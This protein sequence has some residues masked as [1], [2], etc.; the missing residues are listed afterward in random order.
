MD[1]ILRIN[2]TT[3]SNPLGCVERNYLPPVLDKLSRFEVVGLWFKKWICCWSSEQLADW[4]FNVVTRRVCRAM[5]HDDCEFTDLTTM[6]R[7]VDSL[8]DGDDVVA[9]NEVEE[10]T[11]LLRRSVVVENCIITLPDATRQVGPCPVELVEEECGISFPTS[12][13][14]NRIRLA[15]KI[16][17]SKRRRRRVVA[18]CVV[19]LVNLLRAKYFQVSDTE[20]NRKMVGTYLL[21][22]MKER[23]FRTVDMHE[24]ACF[25]VDLYFD[26]T[27]GLKPT[28]YLRN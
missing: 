1:T 22:Q 4:E 12:V 16:K 11:V 23:N 19:A 7:F 9:T 21:R 20:A 24:H 27:S 5:I 17:K 28:V 13:V 18:Y 3:S 15:L 10:P 8:T 14:S 6:Y 26:V 25:A 2:D